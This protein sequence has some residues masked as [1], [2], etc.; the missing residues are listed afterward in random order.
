MKRQR[1]WDTQRPTQTTN[2]PNVKNFNIPT[3]K[4]IRSLLDPGTHV[5]AIAVG[6]S[7]F[8]SSVSSCCCCQIC[9]VIFQ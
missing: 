3:P 7:R 2:H 6:R 8:K 1:K 4:A 9:E 5:I